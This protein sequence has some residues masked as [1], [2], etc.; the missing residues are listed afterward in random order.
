[1]TLRERL[2]A[3]RSFFS[4]Q[5][6]SVIG[7]QDG[8]AIVFNTK[9][10]P[11][12]LICALEIEAGGR[13][14]HGTG[15]LAG[16]RLVVTCGHCLLAPE[17]GGWA[18]RVHVTPGLNSDGTPFGSGVSTQFAAPD[19]WRLHG[20]KAWDVGAIHLPEDIGQRLG[21]FTIAPLTNAQAVANQAGSV[22]GYPIYDD[23]YSRQLSDTDQI[24][25]IAGGRLFHQID[26]DEGQSGAP[27]W[28]GADDQP[29]PTVIAVHAY[30]KQ[31]TPPILGVEAN[32]ATPITPEIFQL[33]QAWRA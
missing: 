3:A 4:M 9:I 23:D 13:V 25:G 5:V 33:I 29:D 32:S 28:L 19:Q 17:M 14:F 6:Q 22:S 1:M 21:W 31:Q 2:T 24:L 8:R 16:P 12:R 27:L 7:S 20:D 10:R 11:A 30:E 18:Q 15:W 26:T